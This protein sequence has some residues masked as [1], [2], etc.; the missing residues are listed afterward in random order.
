[1]RVFG[2]GSD[3][4]LVLGRFLDTAAFSGRFLT[5]R[6]SS[7]GIRSFLASKMA[8]CRPTALAASGCRPKTRV[9]SGC[10]LKQDECPNAARQRERKLR[11]AS[12][13]HEKTLAVTTAGVRMS[14]EAVYRVPK[15]PENERKRNGHTVTSK[16]GEDGRCAGF[17][18]SVPP[19]TA[20][21]PHP[22]YPRGAAILLA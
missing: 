17:N 22:G 7:G 6:A 2:R 16:S 10:R 1:M 18:P 15:T 21:V 13:C 9:V 14:P 5:S 19:T 4:H 12:G 3:T 8:K 11:L 20:P